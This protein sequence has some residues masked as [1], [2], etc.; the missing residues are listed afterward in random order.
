MTK[1]ERETL[2]RK[3]RNL[4]RET[5]YN[6]ARIEASGEMGETYSRA[7]GLYC[8]A[9]DQLHD[10]SISPDDARVFIRA[11]YQPRYTYVRRT[12]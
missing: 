2:L 7:A 11:T 9:C 8:M 5:A 4:V 3:T 1:L 10:L 6:L 12:A